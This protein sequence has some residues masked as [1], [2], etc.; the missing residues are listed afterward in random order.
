MLLKVGVDTTNTHPPLWYY[1]GKV[2]E[3]YDAER[4]GHM[5]I[6]AMT[7]TTADIRTTSLERE[8]SIRAFQNEVIYNYGDYLWCALIIP[9]LGP[10]HIKMQLKEHAIDFG[11]TI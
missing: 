7:E 3:L 6:I 11:R 8:G 2:D 10:P 1:L 9:L 5:V 4:I